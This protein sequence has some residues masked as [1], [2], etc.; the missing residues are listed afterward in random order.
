MQYMLVK[1]SAVLCQGKEFIDF[2]NSRWK[3]NTIYYPN[4]IMNSYI[5][6]YDEQRMH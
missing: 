4:Y 2:I 5:R 1:S 3:V 6:P